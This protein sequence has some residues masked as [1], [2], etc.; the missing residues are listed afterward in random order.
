MFRPSAHKEAWVSTQG[1]AGQ[2]QGQGLDLPTLVLLPRPSSSP[3]HAGTLLN[4]P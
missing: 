1:R 3:L 4:T 2:V